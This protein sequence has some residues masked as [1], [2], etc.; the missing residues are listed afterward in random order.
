[1]RRRT[2]RS[3]L[4]ALSVVLMSVQSA[5]PA[6]AVVLGQSTADS[7]RPARAPGPTG[8]AQPSQA[9]Q[10]LSERPDD[11]RLSVD[12][13][14]ET[15]WNDDG[16]FTATLSG[17]PTRWPSED[18]S[19]WLPYENRLRLATAQE[20]AR[21]E[22]F[23]VAGNGYDVSFSALTQV[24][25]DEPL[26][27]LAQEDASIGVVPVDAKPTLLSRAEA[28]VTYA[29]A[30]PG[31][32]LRYR[33]DGDRVKEEIVLAKAPE[34][35][36]TYV[37]D[38][39]LQG[40]TAQLTDDGGIDFLAAD[41]SVRFHMPRPFMVDGHP[42]I[43]ID[44]RRS[45]AIAV[46]LSELGPS[47][48]RLELRPDLAWLQDPARIYPVVVDPTLVAIDYQDGLGDTAQI[49]Q[50]N[51]TTNYLG[52]ETLHV[53]KTDSGERRDSLVRFPEFSD[54]PSDSVI[55]SATLSLWRTSAS[56]GLSLAADEVT[57]T[58]DEASVTWNNRPS[59]T[60]ADRVS[61]T[62]QTGWNNVDVTRFVRTWLADGRDNHGV[63]LL[64]TDANGSAVALA[65][66]YHPEVDKRPRLEITYAQAYRHG[67]Q[68]I[69][70]YASQQ[71]GG[72]NVS[73][74]NLSTGNVVVQHDGGA[75]PT[76]GFEVDLVSTYNSQDAEGQASYINEF[77]GEGWS[78]S[79]DLRLQKLDTSGNAVAF[80]D[81]RSGQKQIYVKDADAAGR[82]TYTRPVH[83]GYS[84][85]KDLA[86]PPADPAKVYTLTADQ[87]GER[88]FFDA[89]GRLTRRQDDDGNYLTYTYDAS[90]RL[91]RIRDVAGRDTVLE[92]QGA[93]SPARLSRI[94]DM[95]GRVSTYAYDSG[96]LTTIKHAVGTADEVTTTF[97]YG[98][99][100]L[101]TSIRNPRGHTS[102]VRYQPPKFDWETAG[103]ADGWTNG[104]QTT[105]R[106]FT[107]NGSLKVNATVASDGQSTSTT[108]ARTYATPAI[109]NATDQELVAMVQLSS[110]DSVYPI[111]ATLELW[112]QY[113]D[114]AGPS[115]W[116]SSRGLT[117]GQWVAVRIP[118]AQV[119]PAAKIKKVGLR[120][121]L[122]DVE[123]TPYNATATVYVDYFAVRGIGSSLTDA[124]PTPNTIATFD[125]DWEARKAGLSR[126]DQNGIQRRTEYRS[127]RAGEVVEVTDPVGNVTMSEH[128]EFL[129]LVSQ[130]LPGGEA[131]SYTPTATTRTPTTC[132]PS[133]TNWASAGAGWRTRVTATRCTSSTR[134]TSSARRPARAISP[135]R[136]TGTS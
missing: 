124:K 99:D 1:M 27:E 102:Y 74:V 110:L 73:Y 13:V 37:F 43:D 105:A 108:A 79:A 30:F 24:L 76:R 51:P 89:A 101:L 117:P 44:E 42:E 22:A 86:S 77:F 5:P 4:V 32:D 125:Y 65:S 48:V 118:S 107:G 23:V 33:I 60:S 104:S 21:G 63:R 16:T 36:P 134:S 87:G 61:F 129:N 72:G 115:S 14:S 41:K 2:S 78:F 54:M 26:V 91:T 58:W 28:S 57:S 45:E 121:S 7:V 18:G 67:L 85:T 6:S 50:S 38:L 92:Y 9:P 136:S 133:R 123:P 135:R 68:S 96:N 31:A 111:V 11:S 20:A 12:A 69:W 130:T 81:G 119:S 126:P 55:V 64:S 8:P 56:T 35:P 71:Y 3:A 66:N 131:S 39:R 94:T 100:N 25:E 95:A 120:V 17:R 34:A 112:D 19:R 109:W 53:G 70:T 106:A 46:S 97:G 80:Q 98:P 114:P 90:S 84:L 10:A 47:V 93:G 59:S 49:H 29:E 15:V 132:A 40:L 75:I 116:S 128:D 103:S 88:Y 83:Y 122:G 62:S 82:R 127:S 113:T 52:N